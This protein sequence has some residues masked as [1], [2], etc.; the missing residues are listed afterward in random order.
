V[1]GD[2]IAAT[3]T[4]TATVILFGE[5]GPHVGVIALEVVVHLLLLLLTLFYGFSLRRKI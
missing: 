4:A 5:I 2:F 1:L 3:A